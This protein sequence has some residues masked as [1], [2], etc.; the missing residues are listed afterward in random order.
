MNASTNPA[1]NAAID[2]SARDGLFG[3]SPLGVLNVGLSG[4]AGAVEAAGGRV[5]PVAWRPPAGAD[6]DRAW[7]LAVALS[8]AEVAAANATAV[9]AFLAADPVLVDVSAAATAIAA[10]GGGARRLLHAGPPIDYADMCG[11]MQG[12][13]VG[14][15]LFEGWA[16]DPDAA[17]A[18]LRGGAVATEPCHHH[19]AVGPMAGVVSPSMPMWVVEDRSS[20]RHSFSSLNEGLGAVLRFGANGPEVLDRLAWMRDELGPVLASTL[21][22]TRS[23]EA[24]GLPL[25]P[26]MAQALHM[27]DEVHNRNAAATGLLVRRLLP[28]LLSSGA[29][30]AALGR[31][32]TFIGGNDHFFLNLSMAACKAMLR[33]A[34]GVPHSTM[35]TTMA[36]NGVQFGI[37]VS[38][39]GD[40]WFEAPAPVVDGLFFP[41]FGPQDA[42]A[43]LGDSAITET[44]GLGG[45]AMAAAPAIAQFVGGTPADAVANSRRMQ[46]IGIGRNPAFTLPPLGFAPTVAGIDVRRVLDGGVLPVI[47]TGIAHRAAG[48]G[49]IG[50]GITTAPMGC[51]L[52]AFDALFPAS[53][54]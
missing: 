17:E 32:A 23:G 43:D 10:L 26:I 22:L 20:G 30:V 1:M 47:N 18:L 51:F 6:P 8:D 39:A 5:S 14:A 50:A 54:S 16:G 24:G 13:L 12:A 35:V 53:G 48:V 7:R 2:D 33:A 19:G 4:F 31:V 36:R 3:P 34:E 37:R 42:A 28:D 44:A 38:G 29:P 15:V 11:P 46:R 21:R 52:A 9:A 49:Q 27:G 41:G 25:R 45:F 40:R